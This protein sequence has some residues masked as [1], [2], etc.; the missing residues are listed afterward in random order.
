M[1]EGFK[2]IRLIRQFIIF[3]NLEIM[4]YLS[5]SPEILELEGEF[6]VYYFY[7]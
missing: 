4:N 5:I 7:K 1:D 3:D 2:K 6:D